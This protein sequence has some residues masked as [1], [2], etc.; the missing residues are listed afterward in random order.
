[1]EATLSSLG[2]EHAEATTVGW[3]RNREEW[4][5][6]DNQTGGIIEYYE[7]A[8]RCL[9]LIT[10]SGAGY[11]RIVPRAPRVRKTSPFIHSS[12]KLH[13]ITLM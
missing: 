4:V 10:L 13:L 3:V 5:I 8:V 9:G 7:S 2:V 1:M 12:Q 11:R 6:P